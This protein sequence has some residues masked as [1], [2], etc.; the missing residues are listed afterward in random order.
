MGAFFN[1]VCPPTMIKNMGIAVPSEYAKVIKKASKVTC[2]VRA[3]D[4][5]DAKIG[6]TQGV[7]NNPSEKPT[8]TPGKNPDLLLE[9]GTLEES[10]ENKTSSNN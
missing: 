4:I 9:T 6:P 2:P 7:H 1:K 5:T 8:M 3:K 10:L